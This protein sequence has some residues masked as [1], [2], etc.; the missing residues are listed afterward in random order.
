M[1]FLTD[2]GHFLYM[3]HFGYLVT[4]SIYSIAQL[5][6]SYLR[7]FLQVHRDPA[8]APYMWFYRTSFGPLQ[9]TFLLLTYLLH[10]REAPDYQTVRSCVDDIFD[11]F[12]PQ[13]RSSQLSPANSAPDSSVS[14]M[15]VAI[16]VLFDLHR[17]LDSPSR[18]NTA[19]S[20]Q[21]E[22]EEGAP[23]ISVTGFA[24]KNNNH[25]PQFDHSDSVTS[26]SIMLPRDSNGKAQPD[27]MFHASLNLASSQQSLTTATQLEAWSSILVKQ[28]EDFSNHR[29]DRNT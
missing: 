10:F 24:T 27:S 15:P 11:D 5:C 4:N 16:Q 19:Q 3:L 8:F 12:I 17:R 9:S 7:T 20:L 18:I 28:L 26:S 21:R 13:Y 6:L 23:T 22:S 14:P 1:N 2:V 29:V 25:G